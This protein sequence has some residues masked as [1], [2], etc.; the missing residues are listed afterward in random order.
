MNRVRSPN[1]QFCPVALGA[2]MFAERWT[3]LILRELLAGS[4]RFNDLHRGVPRISRA[5]LTSRLA[6][7]E[8]TGLLE[9]RPGPEYHLTEAGLALRPVIDALGRWGYQFA[10][11]ELHAEHLDA[12][13]LMWFLRRRLRMA[14][15]PG[16]RTVMHFRF[17]PRSRPPAFW[18]V[19][20]PPDTDLCTSD[21][22]HDVDLY[23][24]ADLRDGGGLPR[25]ARPARRLARR[26]DRRQRAGAAA[27]RVSVV[28]R[29]QPVR[30]DLTWPR[31]PCG[32]GIR[33]A[34]QL[35]KPP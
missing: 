8:R 3:P 17:R 21:P 1:G 28:D 29:H 23:I 20:Q 24:E 4:H 9:R 31:I 34:R 18:L 13:L 11:T 5:L 25:P 19:V 14:S 32:Q 12:G 10:A 26:P 27:Q 7:L 22:G 16:G 6:G 30:A 2:E 15:L 33:G 35:R